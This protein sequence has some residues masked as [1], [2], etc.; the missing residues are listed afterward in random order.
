MFGKER[1]QTDQT[2]LVDESVAGGSVEQGGFD[3][4]LNSAMI[5]G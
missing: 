4:M 5:C 2:K 1:K 3:V